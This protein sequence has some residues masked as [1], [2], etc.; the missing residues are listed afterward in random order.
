[1]ENTDLNNAQ[2]QTETSVEEIPSETTLST[3]GN[4]SIN[5]EV[6]PIAEQSECKASIESAPQNSTKRM[7]LSIILA[8]IAL[9]VMAGIF[10]LLKPTIL[11]DS[12]PRTFFIQDGVLMMYKSGDEEAVAVGELEENLGDLEVASDYSAAYFIDEIGMEGNLYYVDLKN[13]KEE[14][15]VAEKIASGVHAFS[16]SLEDDKYLIYS[17]GKKTY[18]YTE[19]NSDLIGKNIFSLNYSDGKLL[20]LTEQEEAGA[21]TLN[22]SDIKNLGEPSKVISESVEDIVDFKEDFSEIVYTA[23]NNFNDEG[24]YTVNLYVYKDGSEKCIAENVESCVENEGKIFYSVMADNEQLTY[25]D[26][27]KD[28]FAKADEKTLKNE[29]SVD[30]F[31]GKLTGSS[32]VDWDAYYE[33]YDEFSEAIAR[34]NLREEL[35]LKEFDKKI[36][37]LC[38]WDGKKS[39][40]ILENIINYEIDEDTVVFNKGELKGKVE[41][42]ADITEIESTWD[43]FN[44]LFDSKMYKIYYIYKEGKEPVKLL[45]L[46]DDE[47]Y[48][49]RVKIGDT[50]VLGVVQDVYTNEGEA[51]D[52]MTTLYQIEMREGKDCKLKEIDKTHLWFME[53]ENLI[54]FADIKEDGLCTAFTWDGQEVIEL[55]EDVYYDPILFSGDSNGRFAYLKNGSGGYG[56]LYLL[57]DGKVTKVAKKVV[58]FNFI[59]DELFY[60]VETNREKQKGD[61]YFY[62]KEEP[63]LIGKGI[64]KIQGIRYFVEKSFYYE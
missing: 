61:L 32:G 2:V 4:N 60:V 53:G 36:K 26:F 37:N 25:Y 40:E 28:D 18:V 6:S 43:V 62:D 33:A 13:P 49:G 29:P 44:R 52:N 54:Y 31:A 45:E 50:W 38:V 39:E 8:V 56:T 59:D 24:D 17:K 1:M 30:D 16:M 9:F 34:E 5:P 23:Y 42:V 14:K 55:D 41:P 51:T 21:F 12:H 20:Y 11:E 22:L 27:V 58:E 7:I 10:F 35:K 48:G 15:F 47:Y 63:K 64:T 46:A 3:E 19:G 57:E